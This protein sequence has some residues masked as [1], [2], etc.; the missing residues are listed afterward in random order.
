GRKS[1]QERSIGL[2]RRVS[3]ADKSLKR[4]ARRPGAEEKF[5]CP[6]TRFAV[7]PLIIEVIHTYPH[8][9]DLHKEMSFIPREFVPS[10]SYVISE[11]KSFILEASLGTC[12]GVS[13]C[14]RQAGLGGLSHLLLPEP[15]GPDLFDRPETYA[16]TGLPIFIKALC[17]AGA[18]RSR[19]EA[20]V[21]GG[22][23]VGPL[24]ERDLILDIG[25][26]TAE[27]VERI[28]TREGIAIKKSE[29]GGYFSCSMRLNLNTLETLIQPLGKPGDPMV[30]TDFPKP[31]TDDIR[32][33]IE[34]IQPIPQITLKI[35]RMLKDQACRL[36][37]I[38]N[39]I[40]QDQVLAAKVIRLCN[41]AFF[42]P[43][44]EVNSL[45]R[46]LIML[47]ERQFLRFVI[48]ASME[49]FFEQSEHGYSL[50]KGG[51]HKHAL[52]TAMVA[53][54]LSNFAGNIPSDTAFT[55]GLLHD[56]GKVVLDQYVAGA[57]PYFYRQTQEEG[58]D[59]I[60][61]EQEAFGMTH[62]EAGGSLA[63]AWHLPQSLINVIKYHHEPERATAHP[64]LTCL[65]YVADLVMSRFLVGQE[66]DRL[67]TD[68][69]ALRLKDIG[70]RP[71]TFPLVVDSIPRQ[72]FRTT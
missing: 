25:G 42:S 44:A 61:A 26:R 17:D 54:K 66:L 60:A 20:R 22:A 27:I 15:T 49:G 72:L 31:T 5:F 40:R 46:A 8:C 67:S 16:S 57:Y 45:D 36:R 37:D 48:S 52:G 39:E 7:I 4:P 35:I 2:G 43:K 63:E 3:P 59:L 9:K 41:S 12:V 64:E 70:I 23:L 6:G 71:E 33:V 62:A 38:A 10:G 56:I 65:V 51:L 13:L 24:D 69:L 19:L 34:S 1:W 55:A 30:E 21:A 47:G 18:A 68:R 50:C 28:L 14:D 53:E 32:H 29:T 11:R 58:T